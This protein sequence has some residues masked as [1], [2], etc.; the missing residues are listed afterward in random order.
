MNRRFFLTTLFKGVVAST[1]AYSL[2]IVGKEFSEINPY[3]PDDYADRLLELE[4]A[5]MRYMLPIL[6]E[7]NTA[8]Y[9]AIMTDP[10]NKHVVSRNMRVP[11]Q[12]RPGGKWMT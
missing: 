3:L 6:F 5:K 10:I 7:K 12:I 8:F 2:P 4:L 11:L 9:N 1:V